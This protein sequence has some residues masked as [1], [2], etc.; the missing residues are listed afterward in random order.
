MLPAYCLRDGACKEQ[1]SVPQ[2]VFSISLGESHRL[3]KSQ[4][5]GNVHL[6]SEDSKTMLKMVVYELL[7]ENLFDV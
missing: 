5:V 4:G 7:H 6:V 1:L 2:T 3:E